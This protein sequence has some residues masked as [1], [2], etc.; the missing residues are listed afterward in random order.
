MYYLATK[1]KVMYHFLYRS[2]K[3]ITYYNMTIGT[4]IYNKFGKNNY[5]KSFNN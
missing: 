4:I 3:E 5:Y 1:K 2:Y